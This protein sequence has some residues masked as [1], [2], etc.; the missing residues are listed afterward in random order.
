ML[1]NASYARIDLSLPFG[2]PRPYVPMVCSA[3]CFPCS[4]GHHAAGG[5]AIASV[6]S[7]TSQLCPAMFADLFCLRHG[8]TPQGTVEV[9]A[10]HEMSHPRPNPINVNLFLPCWS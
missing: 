3:A 10:S 7:L 2:V 4:R 9:F 6:R 5:R 1:V 8:S